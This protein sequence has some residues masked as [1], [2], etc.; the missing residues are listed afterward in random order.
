M[1]RIIALLL[2]GVMVFAL[3]ACSSGDDTND[4]TKD[5]TTLNQDVDNKDDLDNSV[6][7]NPDDLD[8]S[9]AG[10]PDDLDNSVAGN[11]DDLVPGDIVIE[12][13]IPSDT[14]IDVT[15]AWESMQASLSEDQLVGGMQLDAQMVTD[16]YGL[17]ET[18][19]NQVFAQVPMMSGLVDE[20]IIVEAVEG[21]LEEV[22]TLILTRQQALAS[23]ALYPDHVEFVASY[24]M[25]TRGNFVIFSVGHHAET[26]I[27]Q[28]ND[29]FA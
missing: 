1:K 20:T 17:D 11:P 2:A 18:L 23:S 16:V 12:P 29:M 15:E 25:S 8:N 3:T 22:Q 28:F 21:K 9:V 10:N 7:G 24:K 14:I 13:G 6:A 5:D 19:V 4:T 26:Y 27:N